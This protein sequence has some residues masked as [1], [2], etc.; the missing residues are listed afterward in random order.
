MKLRLD[1]DLR[2]RLLD[3]ALFMAA[4]A[5]FWFWRPH[6]FFGGDSEIMDR[7]IHEG[8]WFYKREPLCVAAMQLAH[9]ILHPQFHWPP[10]L[11]I[12]LVSS[13]AGAAAVVILRRYWMDKPHPWLS[14]ALCLSSGYVLLFH[15]AVESY[16]LPTCML[17]LWIL[18]IDRVEAGKWPHYLLGLIVAGM[19]W[20]HL[21]AAFLVPALVLGFLLQFRTA[22]REWRYWLLST[23]LVVGLW[24]FIRYHAVG[25][26]VTGGSFRRAFVHSAEQEFGPFFT[27]RHLEIKLYFLWMATQV[28]LPL[29]LL[30]TWK[31]RR[32]PRTLQIAL[33]LVCGLVFLIVFHPDCGK[34]DWDLFMLPSLPAA[35][36]AAQFVV[37]SGLRFVLSGM[38]FAVAA[39]VWLVHVP[40]WADLPHRGLAEVRVL[41]VPTHK[42]DDLEMFVNDRHHLHE[43]LIRLRGGCHTFELRYKG[44]RPRWKVV[45]VEPGDKVELRMPEDSVP[46]PPYPSFVPKR[47]SWEDGP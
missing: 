42:I 10:A 31:E 26:G 6:G 19:M 32:D 8:M 5:W 17:A 18:A 39:A 30:Q 27:L 2:E 23:L 14:L 43:E 44:K 20:F 12:S 41:N 25:E 15:G 11:S 47:F 35:V 33:L 40:V 21:V 28:T 9:R 7:R 36:L 45:C 3:S 4:L 34:R 29:A 46:S 38:W 13:I 1:P 24:V 37:G 16:A 22:L